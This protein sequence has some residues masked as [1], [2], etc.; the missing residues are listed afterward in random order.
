MSSPQMMR[1]LD[2]F[3]SAARVTSAVINDTIVTTATNNKLCSIA[4]IALM[5]LP[6]SYWLCLFAGAK[7]AARF[8]AA[9]RR[10]QSQDGDRLLAR[11][12]LAHLPHLIEHL[13]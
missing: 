10:Y 9:R 12:V 6:R 11:V 8:R 4:L 13:F 3:E 5:I 1:M 2:F 7:R